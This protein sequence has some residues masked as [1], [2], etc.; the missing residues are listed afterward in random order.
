MSD[1]MSETPYTFDFS[2][3]SPKQQYL[4]MYLLKTPL[5]YSRRETLCGYAT[6]QWSDVSDDYCREVVDMMVENHIPLSTANPENH[7]IDIDTEEDV[8]L[9]DIQ[10]VGHKLDMKRVVILPAVPKGPNNNV[11]YDD[12]DPVPM[13]NMAIGC[14]DCGHVFEVVR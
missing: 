11:L 1:K 8:V 7:I 10:C 2:E 4:A 9:S 12:H 14:P 3:F 6:G 5:K 13:S